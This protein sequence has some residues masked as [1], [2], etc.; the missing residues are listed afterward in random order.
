[1][2]VARVDMLPH[3]RTVRLL[4]ERLRER[5]EDLKIRQADVAAALG[6]TQHAVSAWERH[7]GRPRP[8]VMM[9][10]AELLGLELELRLSEPRAAPGARA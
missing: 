2:R 9:A 3:A 10:W 5:R 1:M 6:C 7:Q 8:E 4:I